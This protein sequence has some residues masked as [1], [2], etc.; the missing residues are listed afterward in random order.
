MWLNSLR[1]LIIENTNKEGALGLFF[2][3]PTI[4]CL[5][6]FKELFPGEEKV[7]QEN[8]ITQNLRGN[9]LIVTYWM[10]CT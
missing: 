3:P 2:F 5:D 9:I 6:Y 10:C 1:R 4:I 8:I 7:E